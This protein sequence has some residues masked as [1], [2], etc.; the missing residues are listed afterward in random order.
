MKKIFLGLF[1]LGTLGMAQ[2]NYEVYIKNGVKIS[3]SEADRDSKEIDKII[4]DKIISRYNNEG[5][6]VLMEKSKKL[7][8]EYMDGLMD[9]MV[10][11]APKNQQQSFKEFLRRLSEIMKQNVFGELDKMDISIKEISFLSKNKAKISILAK[12]KDMD[13]LDS[14]KIIDEAFKKSG[15]TDKD[16]E[17]FEKISKVKLDKF[18]KYFEDRVKEEIK[19]IDYNE[20]ITEMEIEKVNGKW[21][22]DFD[23][24][25]LINE[26]LKN[27][28]DSFESMKN[29]IDD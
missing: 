6:K 5:K 27:L 19:K 22:V 20:D 16:T 14:D 15:I 13:D 4:N 9:N 24:N 29:D 28:E 18:Y 7:Y 1:I 11:N 8:D 2:Q 21:Q 23:Y 17:H 12:Y 26:T 3:Q 10:K 25:D